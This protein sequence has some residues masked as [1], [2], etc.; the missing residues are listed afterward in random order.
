MFINTLTRTISGSM[1]GLATLTSGSVMEKSV[2]RVTLLGR[3]GVDPQ[4]RGNERTPVALFTIATNTNYTYETGEVQQKTEWH[5]VSVFKP[6]LRDS[7]M[8]SLKKGSR[9]MV[10]GRLAYGEVIDARGSTHVTSTI[11]ANEVIYL[12][13]RANEEQEEDFSQKEVQRN[14]HRDDPEEPLDGYEAGV[15]AS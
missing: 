4:L 14:P 2:N 13:S 5:R 12:S 10:E 6:Y 11:I 15:K 8:K 7:I 9:V 1:R 3:V